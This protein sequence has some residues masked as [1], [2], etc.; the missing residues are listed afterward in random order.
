MPQDSVPKAVTLVCTFQIGACS[1]L[2]TPSVTAGSDAP[3]SSNAQVHRVLTRPSLPRLKSL[4]ATNGLSEAVHTWA[5]I[6]FLD[7][8]ES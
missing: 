5:A 8:P 7:A 6:S 4:I 2:A 3:E 1:C